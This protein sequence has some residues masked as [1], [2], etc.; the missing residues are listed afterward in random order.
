MKMLNVMGLIVWTGKEG[1]QVYSEVHKTLGNRII[2]TIFLPL[3]MICVLRFIHISFRYLWFS[4]FIIFLLFL[5]YSNFYALVGVMD[6]LVWMTLI[7]PLIFIVEHPKYQL[8]R[9]QTIS[10]SIVSLLIQ[11]VLGHTFFEGVNSRFSPSY[12]LNAILYTPLFYSTELWRGMESLLVS[13]SIPIKIS[14]YLSGD[15]IILTGFYYLISRIMRSNK[16]K[17]L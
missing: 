10:V 8:N 14:Y 5:F 9:F 4:R 11:E 1:L 2:H 16:K 17:D 13:L 15:I 12:I 6:N 7:T 3:I